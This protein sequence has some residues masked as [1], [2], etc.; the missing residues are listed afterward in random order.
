M[1]L[2]L[3]LV[4]EVLLTV[5][6]LFIEL[7][8]VV[9][10]L[11][12]GS[13]KG[14]ASGGGL[15]V[16]TQVPKGG[17]VLLHGNKN[18]EDTRV[19]LTNVTE[20]YDFACEPDAGGDLGIFGGLNTSAASSD[21]VG[22]TTTATS[23]AGSAFGQISI[24]VAPIGDTSLKAVNSPTQTSDS[25]TSNFC[26]FTP[27]YPQSGTLSNGNRTA[28][29]ANTD[30][31]SNE[32]GSMATGTSG[33]YYVEF[34]YVNDNGY[35]SCGFFQA[36]G[37]DIE[38][39]GGEP[40][41]STRML[42]GIGWQEWTGKIRRNNADAHAGNTYT[43]GDILGFYV[44]FDNDAIWCSKNGT[45]ENGA[46]KAEVEAGTTTNAILT[47]TLATDGALIPYVGCVG[48]TNTTFTLNTG[49]SAFNTP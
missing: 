41:D 14:N 18:S 29:D 17:F 44:D 20:D 42:G 34:T 49:Q 33:K 24:S 8:L 6:L 47:G 9:R 45:L 40:T 35:A 28:V 46:S 15:S 31:G 1:I 19:T 12:S 2:F 39:P 38:W 11:I 16:T 22:L 23:A 26:T 32:I 13:I 36:S 4:Q 37:S 3:M 30:P 25:P 43:S 5:V 48:G 21:A 7:Q 10:C 27:L